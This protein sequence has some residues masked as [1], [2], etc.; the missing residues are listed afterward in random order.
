M[1]EQ[2][3]TSH[4]NAGINESELRSWMRWPTAP[5]VRQP[6]ACMTC[7]L[8]SNFEAAKSKTS[9][10]NPEPWKSC[11]RSI[12]WL[13]VTLGS[14]LTGKRF[15]AEKLSAVT[16]GAIKIRFCKLPF[17][18][19]FFLAEHPCAR[20]KCTWCL[21]PVIHTKER[22]KNELRHVGPCRICQPGA[23]S[24]IK[25]EVP[26][27][28]AT[29]PASFIGKPHCHLGAEPFF[30]FCDHGTSSRRKEHK[31]RFRF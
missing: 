20:L 26:T 9:L 7:G 27:R 8:K 10:R 31:H 19:L 14:C 22:S 15:T 4:L 25:R 11:P 28:A 21:C 13:W 3:P 18:F 24:Q 1:L 23:H 2:Q 16:T 6:L 5:S 30:L 29:W 12:G 17:C